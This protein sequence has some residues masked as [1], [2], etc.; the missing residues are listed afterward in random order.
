MA[1]AVHWGRSVKPDRLV[2]FCGERGG[3]PVAIAFCD[4]IKLDD[5]L[6]ANFDP[7]KRCRLVEQF[8]GLHQWFQLRCA[9]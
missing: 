4:R 1:P 9:N 6:G 8:H 7:P 3:Y 2:G 5:D